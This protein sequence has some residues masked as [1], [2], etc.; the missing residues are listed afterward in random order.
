MSLR[1]RLLVAMGAVVLLLVAAGVAIDRSTERNLIGQVDDQLERATPRL[2]LD[3]RGGPPDRDGDRPVGPPGQLY[4]AYLGPTGD[5]IHTVWLPTTTAADASP[6][7]LHATE[8]RAAV[9]GRPFTAKAV[10]GGLR[11]RVIVEDRGRFGGLVISGLPLEDVDAA[12][13]RLRL[14]EVTSITVIVA[15]LGLITFWVLRLGV[16]PLKEMTSTAVAIGDGDLSRRIPESDPSTEA[17]QL[18]T[19]LNRMLGRIEEAFEERARSEDRLRRFVSD[20]SHELRTPV[21]TIRGYAELHRHGGLAD[22]GALDEAMRRT[23][24]EAIR[25]GALVEDLLRLARLDEGRPLSLG[26]VALDEVVA[27]AA[28]DAAAVDRTRTVEVVAPTASPVTVVADEALVRQV[29]ANLVANV[30]EHT[31]PGTRASLAVEV[32]GGDAVV[33]VADDGPGMV[34]DDARRAFERFYRADPSRHRTTGGSGL[35]LSIVADVLAAH[36]GDAG[37]TS[38]PGRGTTVR[39]RFPIAGPPTGTHASS[40]ADPSTPA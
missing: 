31:P 34:A 5:E 36:G 23:E 22:D 12:L 28:R 16:R 9:R 39:L 11:Y 37:L 35:G 15:A 27:D 17:G 30:R 20:A 3:L 18:G 10:D 14:V 40:D 4:V 6:P 21:T 1:A 38:E 25:M 7:D 26:P 8:V 32:V 13:R 33:V 19:A 2:G 29:V 24:A